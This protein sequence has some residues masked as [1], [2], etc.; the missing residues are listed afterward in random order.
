MV[1]HVYY[2]SGTGPDDI[3]HDLRYE[4]VAIANLHSGID[5]TI[6][7]ADVVIVNDKDTPASACILNLL[8]S[9]S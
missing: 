2:S 4:D 9:E 7:P 5:G 1:V 3:V 6:L 8:S